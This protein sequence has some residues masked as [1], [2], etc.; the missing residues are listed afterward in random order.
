MVPLRAHVGALCVRSPTPA[1]PRPCKLCSMVNQ[2][3]ALPM[4]VPLRMQDAACM[5][6]RGSPAYG[7]M[8]MDA[9]S[10]QPLF[11]STRVPCMHACML[12]NRWAGG[13]G[14][15]P[16]SPRAHACAHVAFPTSG[17]TRVQRQHRMVL[18]GLAASACAACPYP[19]LLCQGAAHGR[20]CIIIHTKK[21]N[22]SC[23]YT[24]VSCRT[25][26]LASQPRRI[27]QPKTA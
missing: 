2:S 18:F 24:Q 5:M 12:E 16:S 4:W 25:H 6:T 27:S 15:A 10:A 13:V 19:A 1:S 14:S 9:R 23:R 17:K 3:K 22:I 7:W 8:E 11:R 26:Q 21:V 20:I